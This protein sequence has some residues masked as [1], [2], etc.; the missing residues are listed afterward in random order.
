VQLREEPGARPKVITS[1]RPASHNGIR[2][3]N[4][5]GTRR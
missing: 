2:S 5:G 4:K 3:A 1:Y